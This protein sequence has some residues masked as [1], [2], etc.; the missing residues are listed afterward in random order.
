MHRNIACGIS[1][2]IE[3]LP[4]LSRGDVQSYTK[5]VLRVN[6]HAVETCKPVVLVFVQRVL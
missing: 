1:L 2:E 4:T 6:Y 5:C 3:S